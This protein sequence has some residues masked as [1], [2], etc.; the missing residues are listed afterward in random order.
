M[1][2]LSILEHWHTQYDDL[3]L[4]TNDFYNTL[5]TTLE[6]KAFPNV[7][8]RRIRMRE[9]GWFSSSREYLVVSR[10]EY[11]FIICGSPFGSSFFFSWYMRRESSLADFLGLI[12]FIGKWIINRMM[13]QT[14][15]EYDTEVM[16]KDSIK[17]VV[18]SVLA[19]I[20]KAKGIREVPKAF[21]LTEAK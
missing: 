11:N 20:E 15:Y 3:Q 7:S 21:I 16:F 17:G 18:K 2:H 1:L 4:S 9:T 6:A 8:H 12:P 13:R 10:F 19:E 5:E 14:Y